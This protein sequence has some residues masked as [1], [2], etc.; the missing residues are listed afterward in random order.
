MI[1][2][3]FITK[4]D[5]VKPP[6]ISLCFPYTEVIDWSQ[7]EEKD[8]SKKHPDFTRLV[9]EKYTVQWILEKTYNIEKLL[10]DSWIRKVGK[11]FTKLSDH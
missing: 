11:M 10:H 5:Q 3:V 8:T 4:D 1:S 9:Q 2:E 7:T 6:A